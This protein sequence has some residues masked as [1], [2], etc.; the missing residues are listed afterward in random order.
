MPIL[1][2]SRLRASP[3]SGNRSGRSRIVLNDVSFS[4]DSGKT[5][6][7]L[8]ESGSGKSTI[9]R[10]I[11]GLA[12]PDAGSISFDSM[13]IFPE[14]QNRSKV[15]RGIQ[16]LFQNH[17]ASLDPRMTIRASLME[18]IQSSTGEP[19]GGEAERAAEMYGLPKELL[20]RRPHELSGGQR[21]RVALARA[22]SAAPKLLILDEPTSSLDAAT[23][24]AILK[25]VKELQTEKR[26]AMLYI[27]HD[28]ATTSLMCD[29]IGELKGGVIVET[30]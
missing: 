12:I 24:I 19:D 3:A 8:G 10:C 27:S 30:N 29:A 15:G 22:M 9:A 18:G 7:L 2:V 20:R 16:M 23:Q 11:A 25:L 21:Q 14:T 5:F 4:I 28:L 26:F 6:G 1:E 13:N 17:T